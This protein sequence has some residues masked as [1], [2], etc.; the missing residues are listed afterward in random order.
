MRDQEGQEEAYRKKKNRILILG[1]V[2]LEHRADLGTI[3]V[4]IGMT[5]ER[6]WLWKEE[7][8]LEWRQIHWVGSKGWT[9]EREMPYYFDR[10][11]CQETFGYRY[12]P[13][14]FGI[15]VDYR[16]QLQRQR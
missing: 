2:E 1:I 12:T 5:V 11:L 6:D 3:G 16:P 15:V 14:K 7:D 10:T 9:E 13:S 8:Q 4:E